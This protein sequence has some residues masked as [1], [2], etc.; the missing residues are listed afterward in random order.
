MEED[1]SE[2]EERINIMTLGNQEVGKTCFIIKYTEN[3][4]QEVYLATI[5][6]DFK[7]KNI[8][9]KDMQYKLFFYDTTGQER[10][11]SIS[12]NIIKNAHGII[13]MYDITKKETFE[14]I[15]EWIKSVKE[16]KGDNFP[17]IL[18]GN[19]V[20]LEDNREVSKEE[21]SNFAKENNIEFFETSNKNGI[22][23]NE[24]GKAI[25]NKILEK[26]QRDTLDNNSAKSLKTSKL[27]RNTINSNADNSKKCC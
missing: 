13:L 20:D 21:G 22:N 26:R 6:I 24:A 15:P 11:K 16:A 1:Q 7:V 18:L 17:M 2:S 4:F 25:V 3:N 23:I 9:I 27:N 5:G 10:Y 19:K 8:I 14:S 12:L